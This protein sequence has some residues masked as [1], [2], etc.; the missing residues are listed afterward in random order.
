MPLLHG[1]TLKLKTDAL[2]CQEYKTLSDESGYS[3]YSAPQPYDAAQPQPHPLSNAGN[4]WSAHIIRRF[5]R[6]QIP[7]MPLLSLLFHHPAF[8][9]QPHNNCCLS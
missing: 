8:E 1:R 4:L 3:S 6:L 9:L 2:P 7:Y 5:R